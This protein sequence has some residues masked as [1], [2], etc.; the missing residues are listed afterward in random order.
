MRPPSGGAIKRLGPV[1]HRRNFSPAAAAALTGHFRQ[2]SA[3]PGQ[4]SDSCGQPPPRASVSTSSTPMSLGC[5]VESRE[6][7]T[8]SPQV[9]SQ[10]LHSRGVPPF[11]FMFF[12][13][14]EFFFLWPQLPYLYK[15]DV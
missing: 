5:D 12:F 4:V 15:I 13:F 6:V 3:A 7:L 10:V 14:G 8:D 9:L 1:E 11:F 2:D